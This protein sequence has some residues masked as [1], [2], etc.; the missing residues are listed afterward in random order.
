MKEV[1]YTQFISIIC[2]ECNI[3]PYKDYTLSLPNNK[4]TIKGFVMSRAHKV[5]IVCDEIMHP[6]MLNITQRNDDVLSKGD[7]LLY[8]GY[9]S[10]NDIIIE[11][12][13]TLQ[14]SNTKISEGNGWYSNGKRYPYKNIYTEL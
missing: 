13:A 8:R 2:E 6:Y 5:N 10:L 11:S 9:K 4:A 12:K 3:S 7:Y 14:I 1:S